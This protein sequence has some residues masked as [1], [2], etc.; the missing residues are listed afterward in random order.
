M[1]PDGGARMTRRRAAT[2]AALW[3][4]AILLVVIQAL[5]LRHLMQW[6]RALLDQY[7]SHNYLDLLQVPA[8]WWRFT[9][10]AV[11]LLL[12]LI[13]LG[14]QARWTRVIADLRSGY[15]DTL[16]PDRGTDRSRAALDA[17][18]ALKKSSRRKPRKSA[19]A[20]GSG[21]LTA[22]YPLASDSR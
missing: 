18:R 22:I 10:L 14:L 9:G 2:L 3:I 8:D 21:W 4:A 1:R 17:R 6:N 13:A 15:A 5:V 19:I 12:L 16:A 7:R 11:P 20:G